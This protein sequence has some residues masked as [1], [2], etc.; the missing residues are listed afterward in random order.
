MSIQEKK[1]FNPFNYLM[2]SPAGIEPVTY[3]LGGYRSI[4][5]SYEDTLELN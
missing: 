3:S 2:A 4:L 5:L 1:G